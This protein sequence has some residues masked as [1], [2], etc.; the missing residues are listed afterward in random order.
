MAESNSSTTTVIG[1]DTI[2]KGEMTFDSAAKILGKFEDH[3]KKRAARLGYDGDGK[4]SAS[5]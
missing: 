5:G 3:V 2:I 4:R 1:P